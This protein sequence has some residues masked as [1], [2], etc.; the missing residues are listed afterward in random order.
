VSFGQTVSFIVAL[1]DGSV[2]V[3][4]RPHLRP[5]VFQVPGPDFPAYSW[6]A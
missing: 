2:E 3:E 4:H 1:N 6:T 5:I